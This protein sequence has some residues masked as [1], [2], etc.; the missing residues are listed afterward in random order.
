MYE[1]ATGKESDH[2]IE[3]SVPE[4]DV[5]WNCD[6]PTIWSFT[7]P[8]TFLTAMSG[9][10]CRKSGYGKDI[11]KLSWAEKIFYFNTLLEDEV[12][13]GGFA[14]FFYNSSGNFSAQLFDSLS[15]IGACNTAHIFQKALFALGEC[16]PINREEREA[17]LDGAFTDAISKT[18]SECD[19]AF[20]GSPDNL[21]ALN[22]QFIMKNKAHF[23]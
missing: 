7:D 10:L 19:N 16:L 14:Q 15:A 12:N 13:N 22:Y 20:Y 21:D 17:F 18:L 2:Q 3:S 1:S 8:N 4:F 23:S 11:E 6:F 9:W 5:V